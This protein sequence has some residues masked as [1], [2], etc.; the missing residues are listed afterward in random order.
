MKT[1]SA[2]LV[3]IVESRLLGSRVSLVWHAGEPTAVPIDWYRE[4][5]SLVATHMPAIDVTHHFQTNAVLLNAEW[6]DFIVDHKIS[7]GVSIDGPEFLHDMHRKTR[8]GTGTHAK[9]M[10]GIELLRAAGIPFHVIAVLTR[11]SLK[12]PDA[13][14]DF[15]VG[16]SAIQVGFNVEEVELDN[17]NSSLQG[18]GVKEDVAY[19]WRRILERAELESGRIHIRELEGVLMALRSD[20][21]GQLYGNQQNRVGRIFNV[22]VDGSYCYWSPELLGASH[23]RFGPVILGNVHDEH[24]PLGAEPLL[25]QMQREIDKGVEACSKECLHFDFC[26]GGAPVNKLF[27]RG[28]FAST[29]TMSCQL[30]QKICVDEVLAQ[31]DRTLPRSV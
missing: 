8:S 13:I 26:L 19:F 4:A 23:P 5:F 25:E 21:F 30:G 27:E 14:F 18:V 20:K 31:L 17:T 12:H 2:L 11:E 6:C 15:M 22:A 10:L 9:V 7:V 29:E 16:L 28:T 24:V 3:K 1:L